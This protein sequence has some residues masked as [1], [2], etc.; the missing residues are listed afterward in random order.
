MENH[1][2]RRNFTGDS[3][4]TCGYLVSTVVFEEDVVPSHIRRQEHKDQRLEQP[5]T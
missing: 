5:K 4:R 1:V 3:F 2:C